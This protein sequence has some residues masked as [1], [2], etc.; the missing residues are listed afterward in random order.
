[1]LECLSAKSAH[2]RYNFSVVPILVISNQQALKSRHILLRD[3]QQ[4]LSLGD[5][6]EYSPIITMPI[7]Q[8]MQY[9]H[10]SGYSM[11]AD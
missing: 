11:L 6:A 2:K 5:H 4:A 9:G 7:L 3:Y 1:M 10:S 8:K